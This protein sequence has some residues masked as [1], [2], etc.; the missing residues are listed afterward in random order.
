[1]A[2]SALLLSVA[3][4]ASVFSDINPVPLYFFTQNPSY[5]KV[6]SQS[7]FKKIFD[8]IWGYIS[9][10]FEIRA[11]LVHFFRINSYNN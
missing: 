7:K 9:F 2:P 5:G 10:C 11:H 6:L 8:Q 1:M 3:Y 4:T